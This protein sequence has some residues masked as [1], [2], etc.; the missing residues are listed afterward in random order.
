M[1]AGYTLHGLPLHCRAT[2][3]PSTTHIPNDGTILESP[4]K[5][6]FEL[7]EETKVP[8]QKPTLGQHRK[9][10]F[11]IWTKVFSPWDPW[12]IFTD[13]SSWD[14][15]PITLLLEIHWRQRQWIKNG[16]NVLQPGH[17]LNPGLMMTLS[18]VTK[19]SWS[20]RLLL[21]R[22]AK[23]LDGVNGKKGFF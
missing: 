6:V 16:D 13:N 7:W 2:P 9:V 15:E 21:L 19:L 22:A 11:G 23:L 4:S 20:I 14:H 1:W 8:K 5:D 18:S 12:W 3:R 10:P 17:F